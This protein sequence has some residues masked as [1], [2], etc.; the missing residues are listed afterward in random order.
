[1]IGDAAA[2]EPEEVTQGLLAEV[3]V[4]ISGI[5]VGEIYT[6]DLFGMGTWTLFGDSL[7]NMDL[8]ATLELPDQFEAVPVP[9]AVWLLGSGLIG[10]IGIRRRK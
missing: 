1:V 3:T 2:E 6:V 8:E 4:D 10:L 7:M 5:G 9:A